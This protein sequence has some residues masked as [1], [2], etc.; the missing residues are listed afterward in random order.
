MA[1][2]RPS[3]GIAEVQ[4]IPGG[5][6]IGIPA[7]RQLFPMLFLP[8]WLVGWAFGELSAIADLLRS[9]AQDS[10]GFLMFWLV[11]W[12]LG[13]V[14]AL[15]VFLWMLAGKQIIRLERGLLSVRWE[16][17]GLGFGR[18]YNVSDIA[19]LRIAVGA[20]L[21]PFSMSRAGDMWGYTGGPLVFDYGAHTIRIG[22]GE[23]NY[24]AV[25]Q[26]L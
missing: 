14:G 6:S 2:I 21:N 12:T 17:L 7:P 16:V 13:G 4:D 5:L 3:A 24:F 20:D 25:T 1:L 18:E 11:G 15:A 26:L 9:G 19:N 22:I 10:P 8:V 23:N